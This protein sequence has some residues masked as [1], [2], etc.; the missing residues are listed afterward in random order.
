MA[1]RN[2]RR[3]AEAAAREAARTAA[4]RAEQARRRRVGIVT[5]GLL[6][7]L[8]AAGTAYLVVTERRAKALDARLVAGSCT[9]DQQADRTDGSG[10]VSAPTYAVNPPAGG[11]HLAQAA[12]AGTFTA[13]TAP[14]DGLLVHAL[15]HGYVVLWHGPAA[16]AAD[17]EALRAV[18]RT[19]AEDV[20]VVER[21][22]LPV[23]VA[24][25]AWEQ[26]LLCPAAEPDALEAFVERFVGEGPEKVDRG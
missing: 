14:A 3:R 7:A 8:L 4:S 11:D 15:E 17:V 19:H 9:R 6:V 21:P 22:S 12:R 24:A 13:A 2:A 1:G 20:I 5:I 16:T 26:R 23:P 18:Q 10:H 25:T